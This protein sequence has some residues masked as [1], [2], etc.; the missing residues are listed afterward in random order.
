MN[1]TNSRENI[2]NKVMNESID[3]GTSTSYH[4]YCTAERVM[5]FFGVLPKSHRDALSDLIDSQTSG[6]W[7]TSES[8][9]S[10]VGAKMAIGHPDSLDKFLARLKDEMQRNGFV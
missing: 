1:D 2:I 6:K 10:M 8:I 9:A 5:L 3:G 7:I 4:V